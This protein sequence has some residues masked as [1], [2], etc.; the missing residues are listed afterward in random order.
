MQHRGRLL[1]H[2]CGYTRAV[3]SPDGKQQQPC[4][5]RVAHGRVGRCKN[6]IH[7]DESVGGVQIVGS[8]LDRRCDGCDRLARAVLRDEDIT[9]LEGPGSNKPIV[10]EN[11]V[12]GRCLKNISAGGLDAEILGLDIRVPM[13]EHEH[14]AVHVWAA[15]DLVSKNHI[16]HSLAVTVFKADGARGWEAYD[17]LIILS[18]ARNITIGNFSF[19]LRLDSGWGC[20]LLNLHDV[21]IGRC[22]WKWSWCLCGDGFCRWRSRL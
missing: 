18:S 21:G 3:K 1:E 17:V 7:N 10:G 14:V 19:C 8:T 4:Q 12:V 15:L 9:D 13:A 20:S 22:A 6:A 16:L 5:G 11:I 2:G